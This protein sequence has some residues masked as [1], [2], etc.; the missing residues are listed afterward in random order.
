MWVWVTFK[1]GRVIAF[2]LANGDELDDDPDVVS[3]EQ[4]TKEEIKKEEERLYGGD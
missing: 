3:I 4:M 2:E 1:D